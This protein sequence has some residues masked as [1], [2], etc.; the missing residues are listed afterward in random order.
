MSYHDESS[1][2][3]GVPYGYTVRYHFVPDLMA[4]LVHLEPGD[5][6]ADYRR[7]NDAVVA[8]ERDGWPDPRGCQMAREQI[9]QMGRVAFDCSAYPET[10]ATLMLRL[11]ARGA[12]LHGI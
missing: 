8:V 1:R 4:D 2:H 5:S 12:V 11:Q 10:G 9:D 3:I 6:L 7:E